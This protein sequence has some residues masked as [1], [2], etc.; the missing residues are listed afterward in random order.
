MLTSKEL[1]LSNCDA[2]E[3][4]RVRCKARRS[5]QSILKE[6]HPEYLLEGLM[7][8]LK[9][10]YFATWCKGLTHWKRLWCWERLKAGGERDDRGQDGWMESLTQWLRVWTNSGRQWWTGK[11]G[12]LQSMGLKRVGHNLANEQWQSLQSLEM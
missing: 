9:F 3:L 4:L 11:S 12:L 8:E 2:G 1:M 6:I 7:W 5:N 10:Q